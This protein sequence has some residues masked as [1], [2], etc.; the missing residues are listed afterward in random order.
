MQHGAVKAGVFAHW[1]LQTAAASRVMQQI[2]AA[3]VKCM[4]WPHH[5][6]AWRGSVVTMV[7]AARTLEAGSAGA[8]ADL[9]LVNFIDSRV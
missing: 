6:P 8:L 4:N 2:R 9:V 7:S 5:Y 1:Q 3:A